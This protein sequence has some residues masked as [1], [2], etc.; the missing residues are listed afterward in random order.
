MQPFE[1]YMIVWA[2]TSGLLT[3]LYSGF[4]IKL[5]KG[6]HYKTFKFIITMTVLLLL[7]NLV[8]LF[9]LFVNA[10]VVMTEEDDRSPLTWDWMQ[11]IC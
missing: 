11:A 10:E 2:T 8:T 9:Q 6:V 1:D 7:C 3:L 5:L 4:L